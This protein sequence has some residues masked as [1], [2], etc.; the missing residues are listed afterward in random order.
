MVEPHRAT[1]EQVATV[2]E[3]ISTAAISVEALWHIEV[4]AAPPALRAV[5]LRHLR[6]DLH[7]LRR[8]LLEMFSE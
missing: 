5:E 3:T 1:P 7:D 2:A 8:Q 4:R 6:D